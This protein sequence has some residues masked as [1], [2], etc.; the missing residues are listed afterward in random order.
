MESVLILSKWSNSRGVTH[1]INRLRHRG[2]RPVLVTPCFDLNCDKCDDYILLDW[3]KE[4]LQTLLTQ[5]DRRGI[6]PVAIVNL[7]ELLNSW[8]IALAT[9][10]GL[11]GSESFRNLL[12]SKFLVREHMQAMGLSNIRF[13]GDPAKVDFFPAIVKL[14][15]EGSASFLVRRV[16]SPDEL[17]AYQRHLAELGFAEKELIIEEFLPGAEFS[18][19]GPAV[20]GRFYPALAGAMPDYDNTRLRH[21]NVGL[22]IHPPQRDHIRDGVRALHKMIDAFCADLHLDQVWLHT[23]GRTVEGGRA[24]LVEINPRPGGGI[25]TE[26]IRAARGIDQMDTLISMSLGQFAIPAEIP[27]PL[28]APP[29]FGTADMD[30][31]ELGIVEIRNT[32]DEIRALPGVVAVHLANGLQV[33][34]LEK[35]NFYIN[36]LLTADSVE[37]LRDRYDTVIN[38]IDYHIKAP[39]PDQSTA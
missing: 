29:L 20:G 3:D 8:Q 32:E 37:Q 30:A 9:H 19:D 11:P 35:E 5:I 7:V 26:A 21:H 27:D 39:P 13:S 4:D 23:E 18:L 6:K 28:R 22:H 24:E 16:D 1:V 36:F 12:A 10:Y 34:T 33:T 38:A 17:S 15:R 25:L 14:S 2:L 31:K